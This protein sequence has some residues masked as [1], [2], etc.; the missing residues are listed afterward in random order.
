MSIAPI[1]KL[2]CGRW[3]AFFCN[4][5]L[6]PEE[7]A[8]AV[9][10]TLGF[11]G[12]FDLSLDRS[13]WKYGK[14]EIN[15]LVLSWRINR[16]I[17]IPLMFIELDKA[18]NSNTAERLDLLEKFNKIFGFDRIRSLAADREFIGKKWFKELHK[19]DIP[20]FIRVKEN[21]LLPWGENNPIH[22]RDLF[23]HLQGDQNRLVQ[24]EMYGGTVY[25]VGIRS[26]SG[27]MVI[28]MSNQDLKAS[29]I[30]AK[31]R[32]RWAIEELFRKLKTSGFHW[33]NTHMV[34]SA[35]LVSLLIILSFGVLIACLMG[36]EQKIPWKKTL[37]CPLYSVFKQGLIRFQFLLAQSVVGVLE[38]LLNLL[39]LAKNGDF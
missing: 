9:V 1:L 23:Q 11:K 6:S 18:G 5:E 10:E 12:K 15:Y 17:S 16:H 38:T 8:K 26:K 4:E 24:K 37:D 29:Q 35:R 25:F 33:E 39:E 21:T 13:N 2:H 34:H 3:S 19:Y 36:Q 22:A 28:V 7:Y 20:Y 32:E 14:K 27:D 30:L 31:Y